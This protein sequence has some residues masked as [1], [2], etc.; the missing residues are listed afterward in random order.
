MFVNTGVEVN[1]NK[2]TFCFF[3]PFIFLYRVSGTVLISERVK[4][5]SNLLLIRKKLLHYYFYFL[6]CFD[7]VSFFFYLFLHFF[8]NFNE[9]FD[10]S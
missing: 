7:D 8:S 10:F 5:K 4:L 6:V 3:S 1:L 2:I 9:T